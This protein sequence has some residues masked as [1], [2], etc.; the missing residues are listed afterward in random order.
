MPNDLTNLLP[1]ERRDA[2]VRSYFLRLAVVA[3]VAA[4]LLIVASMILLV[5]TYILLTDS[6]RTKEDHLAAIEAA[7]VSTNQTALSSRLAALS[8]DAAALSRLTQ[9]PSVSAIIRSALALSRPGVTLSNI[10]YTPSDG[11][12]AGMLAISGIARTREALRNYQ[13]VLQ[14][15][16][17]AKAAVLPVSAYAKDSN[18]AFTITVTLAP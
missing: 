11:A 5:P 4:S 8:D 12:N 16:S 6:M 15:A 1:N 2:L 17:F 10:S 3:V 14:G 9:N 18:I 13:L 7:L